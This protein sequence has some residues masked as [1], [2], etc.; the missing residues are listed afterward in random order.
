M[1][2]KKATSKKKTSKKKAATKKKSAAKTRKA[3]AAV[4]SI[5]NKNKIKQVI[6]EF[7]NAKKSNFQVNEQV[8]ALSKERVL[9]PNIYRSV[10]DAHTAREAEL[11]HFALNHLIKVTGSPDQKGA[12]DKL[13]VQFR[14]SIAIKYNKKFKVSYS[15][16]ELAN[17]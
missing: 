6:Y 8:Q 7:F 11:I 5:L 10:F 15:P 13:A 17:L 4:K 14:R 2:K 16:D 3:A 1:T 12:V 9:M